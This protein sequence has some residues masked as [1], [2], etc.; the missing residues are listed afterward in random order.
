MK[1]SRLAVR[2]AKSLID[3]AVEKG[4]VEQVYAD[5][6]LVQK[7]CKES[8]ELE[9]LFNSPIVKTDKK[10]AILKALFDGKVDAITS[11]YFQLMASKR[12]ESYIP[13]IAE[14]YIEKY[15]VRKK[16]LTAV[17][18]TAY[19]LDD[20]VRAKV[21]KLVKDSYSSEVELVEKVDKNIIGGFILRIG[22]KQDDTSLLRKI[23]MLTR[24][25]NEN[26]YIKDY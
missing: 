15:K 7:T 4:K 1:G 18:T 19:G 11:A 5:M 8:H 3:L 14:S 10:Q 20:D 26:P 23:K 6:K 21:M 13:A 16:I 24:T 17:I 22:D 9:L 25:F 12:R 2:Y